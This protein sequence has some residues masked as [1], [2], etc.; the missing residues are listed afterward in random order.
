MCES[1]ERV[2]EIDANACRAHVDAHFSADAMVEGYLKA[3]DRV[4]EG[5]P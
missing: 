4:L 5:R 1:V 2:G 3:F